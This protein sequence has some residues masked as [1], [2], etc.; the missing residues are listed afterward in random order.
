MTDKKTLELVSEYLKS[1]G[2]NPIRIDQKMFPGKRIPDFKVEWGNGGLFYCEVKSPILKLDPKTNLFKHITTMSKLRYFIHTSAIQFK[3]VNPNHII[4]NILIWTSDHFQ[5][6]YSNLVDCLRGAIYRSGSSIKNLEHTD[7]VLRTN[8]DIEEID[9]H[10][11]LQ[12]SAQ[13]DIY[14]Q[15]FYILNG[16]LKPIRILGLFKNKDSFSYCFLK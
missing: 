11:W 13:G 4:P 5:L 1:K 16:P 3:S 7:F 9:L 14:Q 10:I 6:N 2:F 8:K 15:T 12:I